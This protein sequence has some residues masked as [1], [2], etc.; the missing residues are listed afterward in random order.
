MI[1]GF[2]SC[3]NDRVVDCLKKTGEITSVD[4]PVDFFHTVK[5]L[6]EVDIYL[7]NGENQRIELVAGKNLLS[8]I[9]FEVKDSVLTISNNN[10]CNWVRTPGNPGIYIYN[11]HLRR[12][13]IYDYSNFYTPD[14]LHLKTMELFSDG[15]GDFDLLVDV[16]TLLVESIYISNFTFSGKVNFLGI[17]FTDDSRF[18]GKELISEYNIIDH[19]GSNLIELYPLKVL[20]GQLNSTGDLYFYHDPEIL[21]VVINH[22]GKLINRTDQ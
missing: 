3:D 19:N 12:I 13:E 17:L 16:D 4:Y 10:R 22:S 20:S 18:N 7:L 2:I 8:N 21:D 15:T 6:D 1:L 14:S 5:V 9:R 11:N